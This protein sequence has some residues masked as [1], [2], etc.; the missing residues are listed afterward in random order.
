MKKTIVLFLIA[1]FIFTLTLPCFVYANDVLTTGEGKVITFESDP[2][3]FDNTGGIEEVENGWHLKTGNE[4]FVYFYPE[5]VSNHFILEADFTDVMGKSTDNSC[6]G[7]TIADT[8]GTYYLYIGAVW[9]KEDGTSAFGMTKDADWWGTF[10]PY[11]IDFLTG[12]GSQRTAHMT[13]EYIRHENGDVTMIETVNGTSLTLFDANDEG[14][15]F[16]TYKNDDGS[17]TVKES[18]GP[19]Y[20]GQFISLD[21]KNTDSYI[22]NFRYIDLDD[23]TPEVTDKPEETSDIPVTD[24]KPVTDNNPNPPTTDAPPV[25]DTIGA[26]EPE[27]KGFNP[28]YVI[29]PAA[30]VCVIAA[31]AVLIVK[32]KK[33]K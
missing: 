10:T 31:A 4:G 21:Q 11:T 1:A 30:A 8:H 7:F 6:T 9:E 23:H 2:D 5:E 17:V 24:N 25:I 33:S 20:A 18:N 32:G 22:L 27:K 12:E 16:E 13:V 29:I 3:L 26:Q 19:A 15:L 14:K 28:L